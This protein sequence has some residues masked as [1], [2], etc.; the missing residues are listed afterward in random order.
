M[1]DLTDPK[2][3]E[4][5]ADEHGTPLFIIDMEKIRQNY[6]LFERLFPRVQVYYA[7][8]SNSDPGIVKTLFNLGSRFDVASLAEFN[9]VYEHI[10]D[11]TLEEQKAYIWDKIIY[12]NTIKRVDTL[13][14]LNKYEPLVTYDNAE[15]L[16]KIKAHCPDAGVVLRVKVPDTGSMVPL[17]SKFGAH[18]GE[19]VDLILAAAELGLTVEGLSFHVGSQCVNNEN[20]VQALQI[21]HELFEEADSRG[22]DS[23]RLLDIGG[24]FP[25]EYTP[26]VHPIEQLAEIIN[27]ELDR[28]FPAETA[29]IAEPGRF[30]SATA[31]IVVTKILGKAVREGKTCYYLDDGIYHTFSGVIFDHQ[32][33]VLKSIKQGEPKICAVFGPTCDSLDTI[34]LAENLP[35]ELE[36][37]DYLYAENIGSY[38]HASSTWFNGFPPAT[39]LRVNE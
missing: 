28:L 32:N 31:G 13:H 29:I 23:L 5:L 39:V 14:I 36:L 34:S 18:P 15:E 7:V 2:V 10:K 11:Y 1:E 26:E 6:Y 17:S 25:V 21:C 19:A 4:K 20:F 8:K 30:I 24:G 33:Y 35:E 27:S 38:S 9:L 22:I 16:K 37:E 3:L 12:A